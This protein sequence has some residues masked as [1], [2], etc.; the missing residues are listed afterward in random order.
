MRRGRERVCAVPLSYVL[1]P[2]RFPRRD[3]IYLS[4]YPSSYSIHP[5]IP[6]LCILAYIQ[7]LPLFIPFIPIYMHSTHS[8]H[9]FLQIFIHTSFNPPVYICVGLA[10]LPFLYFFCLS[11]FQFI[12]L[13]PFFTYLFLSDSLLLL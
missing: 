7:T 1:F 2:L 5:F 4:I 8:I 6:L 13:Y 10:F 3:S 9:P 12:I 11:F